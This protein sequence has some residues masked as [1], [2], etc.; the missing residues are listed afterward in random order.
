MKTSTSETT[1]QKGLL[2][3]AQETGQ[4]ARHGALN[5]C[6]SDD[7]FR[8]WVERVKGDQTLGGMKEEKALRCKKAL[9]SLTT[10]AHMHAPKRQRKR[11]R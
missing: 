8:L 1:T 9:R 3:V 4:E 11:L 5:A 10:M 6:L 2:L 7:R